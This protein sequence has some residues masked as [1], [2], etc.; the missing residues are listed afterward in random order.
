MDQQVFY[1]LDDFDLESVNLDTPAT[2]VDEYMKQVHVTRKL[3][4]EVVAAQIDLTD[5]K[6]SPSWSK[7]FSNQ[8][9][10]LKPCLFAPGK[11]WQQHFV[12][13]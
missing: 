8:E 9:E 7:L 2:T 12:S 13:F 3:C 5:L 11:E 10:I 6:C 4:P 1:Q